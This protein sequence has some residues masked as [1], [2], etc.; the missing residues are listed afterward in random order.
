[1]PVYEFRCLD[2]E[3]TFEVLVEGALF[4][5]GLR[6]PRCRSDRVERKLS[7]FAA[8]ASSPARGCAVEQAGLEACRECGQRGR[9]CPLTSSEG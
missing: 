8:R 3:R 6:C 5:E 4:P 1:M 2:C 9:T 7:V